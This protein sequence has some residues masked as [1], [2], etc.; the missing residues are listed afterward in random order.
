MRDIKKG[1]GFPRASALFLGDWN[2]L[3]EH[4]PPPSV[5]TLPPGPVQA[6]LL[7]RPGVLVL[8]PATQLSAA[9]EMS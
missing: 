4:E 6:C 5:M 7:M 3:Q 8:F 9:S 2:V 1:A